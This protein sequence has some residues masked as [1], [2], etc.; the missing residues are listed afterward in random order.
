MRHDF[1]RFTLAR[2]E[3]TLWKV[4]DTS[5]RSVVRVA[6]SPKATRSGRRGRGVVSNRGNM[7]LDGLPRHTRT[8]GQSELVERLVLVAYTDLQ[9]LCNN[10]PG[11]PELDRKRE[12]ARYLHNLRQRLTRLH[13]LVEWAP[14]NRAAQIAVKCGDMMGQLRQHDMAFADAADRLYGLRQQMDWA[15]GPLYDTPGALDVL[16]NGKYSNLPRAIADVAPKP[17]PLETDPELIRVRDERC[18]RFDIEIRG[19][20]V[21]ERERGTMPKAMKVFSVR[22]GECVVGVPGEYRATLTLGGPPPLPPPPEKDEKEDGGEE[23]EDGGGDDDGADPPP[24]PPPPPKLGGWLVVSIEM[25]AGE[26]IDA[27]E[28]EGRAAHARV[29]PLTKTEVKILGRAA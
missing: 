22:N 14:K 3:K 29:F 4:W 13:V 19:L 28:D 15:A 18:R 16:C 1:P 5:S 17:V 12:L 25:L 11:Q 2:T 21:D 10:L 26:M 24:P 20:L 9:R 27:D 8:V 7:S 23:K 6:P